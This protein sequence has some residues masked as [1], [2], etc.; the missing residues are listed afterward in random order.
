MVLVLS[1]VSVNVLMLLVMIAIFKVSFSS[2]FLNLGFFG[3]LIRLLRSKCMLMLGEYMVKWTTPH[4][5]L[6]LSEGDSKPYN[7]L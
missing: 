5:Y 4:P 2:F 1:V 7:E 6:G 3:S